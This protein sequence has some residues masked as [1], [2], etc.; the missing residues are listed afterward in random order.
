MI[1]ARVSRSLIASRV[2]NYAIELVAAVVVAIV[3]MVTK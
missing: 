2:A 1:A 3:V